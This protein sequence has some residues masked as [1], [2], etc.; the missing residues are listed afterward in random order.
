MN[1]IRTKW[2]IFSSFFLTTALSLPT[3]AT[4]MER[5]DDHGLTP[6]ILYYH[7]SQYQENFLAS[8]KTTVSTVISVV[9]SIFK[10]FFD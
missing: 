9:K 5:D 1:K 8:V 6:H 7:N 4:A 3:L 10:W 2:L